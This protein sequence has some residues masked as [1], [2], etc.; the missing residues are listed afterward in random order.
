[1]FV[2]A[3]PS[4]T[5]T[6]EI[7]LTPAAGPQYLVFTPPICMAVP[8]VV[9]EAGGGGGT[10][11]GELA[12]GFEMPDRFFLGAGFPKYRLVPCRQR[13]AGTVG[14]TVKVAV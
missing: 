14:T 4:F 2:N 12:C 5:T 9:G 13:G 8:I 6:T 11:D 10:R 7:P 1:M 3:S